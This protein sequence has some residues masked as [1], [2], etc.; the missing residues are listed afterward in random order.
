MLNQIFI[1]LKTHF[2]M[3][4]GLTD[5]K[6]LTTGYNFDIKTAFLVLIFTF[7]I[8]YIL[9]MIYHKCLHSSRHFAWYYSGFVGG[10]ILP[11]LWSIE[12][13]FVVCLTCEVEIFG[14]QS[15]WD[16]QNWT[17]FKHRL[18]LD[19]IISSYIQAVTK[20]MNLI[21]LWSKSRDKQITWS[22][23]CT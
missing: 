21:K 8:L 15:D 18:L 13:V 17:A 22:S 3:H 5:F 9:Y 10:T 11:W 2:E 7:H 19:F 20:D 16:T 12:I 4:V 6:H 1:E 23:A 14:F